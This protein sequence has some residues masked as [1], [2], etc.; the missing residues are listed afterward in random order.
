MAIAA[1]MAKQEKER[2]WK[3][4]ENGEASGSRVNVI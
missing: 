1:G 2:R 3:E 4:V